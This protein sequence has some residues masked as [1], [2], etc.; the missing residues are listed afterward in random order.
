MHKNQ[1]HNVHHNNTSSNSLC[2]SQHSLGLDKP[3]PS[4][5][6]GIE[7]RLLLASPGA[8]S[9]LNTH[10]SG[11]RNGAENWFSAVSSSIAVCFIGTTY[12][13]VIISKEKHRYLSNI[14]TSLADLAPLPH[15]PQHP[16]PVFTFITPP[17]PVKRWLVVPE[18]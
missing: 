14:Q 9:S 4:A 8:F 13:R 12:T 3:A 7:W 15:S 1:R 2:W 11:N 16:A 17:H 6:L 18:A 5:A 10:L